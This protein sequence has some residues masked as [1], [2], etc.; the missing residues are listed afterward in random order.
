MSQL[1]LAASYAVRESRERRSAFGD[2]DVLVVGRRAL[3][4]LVDWVLM[5][6]LLVEFLRRF[7][8]V[9]TRVVVSFSL[10][11]ALQFIP[12]HREFAL[13]YPH[14]VPSIIL[15]S[16]WLAY[17]VIFEAA[18]GMTIGKWVFGIRVVDFFGGNPSLLQ[19]LTRNCFR[20]L[21]GYPFV[22]PELVGLAILS[23]N[24]RR[25]RGGDK[26]AGTLVVDWRACRQAKARRRAEAGSD[27]IPERPVKKKSVNSAVMDGSRVDEHDMS[28]FFDQ[29]AV[30][31]GSDEEQPEDT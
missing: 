20:V 9:W 28:T 17:L 14:V 21:D 27:R 30:L 19:S 18:L 16:I 1:E 4:G 5:V 31:E 7:G 10:P 11:S 8:A 13:V 26:A 22:I 25:Q 23:T 24:R 29:G 6:M 3:A 15:V 2:H 12:H